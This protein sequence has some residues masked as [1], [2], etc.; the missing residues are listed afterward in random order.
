MTGTPGSP[1]ASGRDLMRT[2]PPQLA[3]QARAF[4]E[5]P[6][7][8]A[9]PRNAASVV[10]LR[11]GA[12]EVEFYLL[13]RQ[14][15]MAFAAGMAVFPGG[16][17]DQRDFDD[18][19]IGWAG[20]SL[21]EWSARLGVDEALARALLF[22]AVR[23]TFEESGVLLAGPSADTVISD[24]TGADWER[25]REALVSREL[26]LTAFAARR[27]LVIRTDLLAPWAVWVTPIFQPRRYRTWFFLAR[28]PDGQTARDV[29]TEST[30]TL[31][32]TSGK[33]LQGVHAG[34]LAMMPPQYVTALELYGVPSPR[35][36]ADLARH[37]ELERIE[38]WVRFA[39]DEAHLEVPER[40]VELGRRVLDELGLA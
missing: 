6:G 39:G 32:T 23:E 28:L 1:H 29:S 21:A 24:T 16:S 35:A 33:A 37:R 40:L 9:E 34:T 12:G 13:L 30:E 11:P 22:A 4:A 19:H 20:P 36:A 10:L 3:S 26:S 15:S 8:P 2:L 5:G 7:Q 31:W 17:V 14:Q 38:P 27:D 25:D 18:A